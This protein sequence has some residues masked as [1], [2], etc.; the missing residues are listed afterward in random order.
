MGFKCPSCH[1]DF[2]INKDRWKKHLK[3]HDGLNDTINNF[4]NITCSHKGKKN[5]SQGLSDERH[6]YCP[7]C[8]WHEYK[9]KE[10]TSEEWIIYVN[11]KSE[12]L[13]TKYTRK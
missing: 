1:E 5:L 9:G 2:G 7:D 12:P 8:K 10:Y 3:K 4:M 11:G 13:R 6:Y